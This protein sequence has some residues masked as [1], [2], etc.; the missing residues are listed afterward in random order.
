MC[1]LISYFGTE[2]R[3]YII[4]IVLFLMW[5]GIMTLFYLKADEVTK[6]PCQVCANKLNNDVV[7]SI[8]NG[9]EIRQRVYYPNF[10]I[11]DR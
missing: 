4:L 1:K 2:K 11:L 5:L 10:T 6:S 8:Q 9:G 7:C 3:F